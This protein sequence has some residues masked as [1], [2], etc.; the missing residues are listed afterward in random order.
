MK[1]TA[2]SKQARFEVF[3]RDSFKCQYCGR[4]A[5]DVLLQ[6]DHIRPVSKGGGG[7][8]LNL[9]TSC[10]DCNSGKSDRELSDNSVLAKQRA[11]LEELNERRE[12]LE[13][14]LQWRE[15]MRSISEAELGAVTDRYHSA[16]P[17]WQLN[18]KGLVDMRKLMRRHGTDRLLNAIDRA[19]DYIQVDDKG[20]ATSDSAG[21]FDG[22]IHIFCQPEDIQ[23]LYMIR[24]LIRKRFMYCNDRLAITLLRRALDAGA[25]VDELRTMA[26]EISNWSTWKAEMETLLGEGEE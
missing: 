14:M 1:R 18:D 5:P 13:L 16:C 20:A 9:I 17:G 11:Q 19:S 10:F 8:I 6:V 24:G 26:C 3:K 7:D 12:Q 4:A 23:Q 2:I 25:S 21:K 22:L 15:G